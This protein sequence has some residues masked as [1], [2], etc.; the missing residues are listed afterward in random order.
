MNKEKKKK[1]IREKKVKKR[2]VKGK[3]IIVSH[4][5][6]IELDEVPILEVTVTE[7]WVEEESDV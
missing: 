4:G 5:K 7:R 6:V 3:F 1:K 2:K